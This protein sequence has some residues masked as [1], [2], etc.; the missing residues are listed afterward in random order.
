MLARSA[1]ASRG[2]ILHIAN[3]KDGDGLSLDSGVWAIVNYAF[4]GRQARLYSVRM[5]LGFAQT[6]HV[7]KD[8]HVCIE[9]SRAG[10][11]SR[12]RS[13]FV[14]SPLRL[15]RQRGTNTTAL[16]KVVRRRPHAMT[17]DP[18]HIPRANDVIVCFQKALQ[19]S[20]NERDD[21]II[22]R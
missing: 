11:S 8:C 15:V 13:A 22:A 20:A 4:S 18:T 10:S 9:Y 7:V 14:R 17:A 5:H 2:H 1:H 3:P 21:H 6:L 16:G 12:L 19:H